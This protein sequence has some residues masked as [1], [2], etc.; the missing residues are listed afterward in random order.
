VFEINRSRDQRVFTAFAAAGLLMLAAG[1]TG[2]NQM[3]ST[4]GGSQTGPETAD[5]ADPQAFVEAPITE[6]ELNTLRSNFQRVHFDFDVAALDDM[7]RRL[8]AQNAEI[9]LRH[10]S[11]SVRI[12]GHADHFGSDE[13]NLAL[14]QRRAETVRS[15]LLALGVPETRLALISYGE[16][17]PLVGDGARS[18]QEPNRRAEFVVIQGDELAVSSY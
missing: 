13:Y 17:R 4:A 7:T 3:A 16:L 1:C 6:E 12:E 8:L 14:G 9:L 18:T 10:P 5:S 15:Y 2:K 11:V